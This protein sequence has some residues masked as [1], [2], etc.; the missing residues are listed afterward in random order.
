MED[1][2]ATTEEL[3][4]TYLAHRHRNGPAPSPPPGPTAPTAPAAP[5]APPAPFLRELLLNDG[6]RAIACCTLD[7]RHDVFL[8]DH[9]FGGRVSAADPTLLALPILPLTFSMELLCEAGALLAPQQVLTGM[10]EVRTY[11]WIALDL[12][13]PV[14]LQISAVHRDG[15]PPGTTH[16]QVQVRALGAGDAPDRIRPGLPIVEATVVFAAA[17]PPAPPAPAFEL[18]GRRRSRWTG[19]DLYD[20]FMFHGPSLRSVAS[21]DAWGT[22][23]M[24]ATLRA[25]PEAPLFAPGTGVQFTCDPVVLDGAGQVVAYWTSD[26]LPRAYHVFPF[27]LE[28]LQVFGPPLRAPEQGKCLARIALQGDQLVRSDIDVLDPQGRVRFRL[29]GWWDRRFELPQRFARAIARPRQA[30]FATPCQELLAPGAVAAAACAI[31][32][33]QGDFLGAHEHL[34]ERVVTHIALHRE[35]RAQWSAMDARDR[36][37]REWLLGRVAAKDAVRLL[38]RGTHGVDLPAADIEIGRDGL[39][40]PWV[41]RV[42]G[43]ALDVL[44]QVSIAHTE[45]IAVAIAAL[46][47]AGAGLGVDVQRISDPASFARASFTPEEQRALGGLDPERAMRAFCA[48]EAF[49]KAL[50]TG[51]QG[52]PT[53]VVVRAIDPT[54]QRLELETGAGLAASHPEVA[55]ARAAVHTVRRG[56]LVLATCIRNAK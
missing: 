29:L 23:G 38:L 42:S 46:L 54:G 45:G 8:A 50:G 15:A 3:S 13:Q 36:R 32:E 51:F 35:E 49:A 27:R 21:V 53:N 2:L 47:P 52:M 20:G 56:D 55:G 40:K 17:R 11:R 19:A 4:R 30:S 41:T 6:H 22:D 48:K 31:D 10:R 24:E 43:V 12:E 7:L 25:M 14:T 33:L 16:V 18:E 26:H 28:E 34:W 37:R 39:G 1:L 44:P 9:T 5:T